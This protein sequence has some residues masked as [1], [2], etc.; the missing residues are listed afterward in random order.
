MV[1]LA[2]RAVIRGTK[3]S[4][5]AR[6]T[7]LLLKDPIFGALLMVKVLALELDDL[8]FVFD[9]QLAN[10]AHLQLLC[11][12]I[13][14]LSLSLIDLVE[15]DLV[16]VFLYLVEDT[17]ITVEPLLCSLPAHH[18]HR[19]QCAHCRNTVHR[20]TLAIGNSR[21]RRAVVGHLDAALAGHLQQRLSIRSRRRCERVHSRLVGL[22]SGCKLSS[23]RS[24]R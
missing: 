5:A 21:L 18:V 8:V 7:V 17:S 14:R 13:D 11:V 24:R 12:V 20:C 15:G 23:S 1:L 2:L 10:G 22:Q 4:F 6:W 9:W 19:S 3:L 16:I